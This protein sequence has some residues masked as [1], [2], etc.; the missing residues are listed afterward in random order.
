LRFS[1]QT[2]ALMASCP[3]CGQAPQDL[4]ARAVL[5]FRLFAVEALVAPQLPP[6]LFDQARPPI[7]P[8]A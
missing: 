3:F 1:A 2:A 6:H 8:P 5:G 7:G 4:E